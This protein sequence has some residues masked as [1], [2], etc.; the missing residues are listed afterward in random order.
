[1]AKKFRFELGDRVTLKLTSES[2]EVIG[3]AEYIDSDPHY[4]IRYKTAEG[5]QTEIWWADSALL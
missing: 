3:R 1:M 4:Q 5:R 2:G